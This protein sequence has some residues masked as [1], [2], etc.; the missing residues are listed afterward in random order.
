MK[1]L[2]LHGFAVGCLLSAVHVARAEDSEPVVEDVATEAAEEL[3][4]IIGEP[5]ALAR[6]RLTWYAESG[7]TYGGG[8]T[9]PGSAACSWNFPLG[10]RF[11]FPH[12]EVVTCND[13]GLLGSVG[14]LDV[15]RR[16]DLARMYGS[17]VVVE[18]LP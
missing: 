12:G 2:F 4:P 3:E 14:W 10:T 9:Y 1:R 7:I 5:L 17:H 18:V 16:P 8:H 15:F 13:R 6:V 11:R